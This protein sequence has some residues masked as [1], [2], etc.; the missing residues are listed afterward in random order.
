LNDEV[1]CKCGEVL[2][3]KNTLNDEPVLMLYNYVKTRNS[4]VYPAKP[5]AFSNHEERRQTG[6]GKMEKQRPDA[7]YSTLPHN[8]TD[9]EAT[10]FFAKLQAEARTNGRPIQL[11]SNTEFIR[12]AD[13]PTSIKCRKCG[14]LK[15]LA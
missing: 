6:K 3:Y 7:R 9:E 14:E 13:L 8:A 15:H 5:R 12:R 10:Q 11:V 2:G 1:F 4:Y